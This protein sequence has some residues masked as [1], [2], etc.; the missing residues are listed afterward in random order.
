MM[1]RWRE[2]RWTALR[3]AL[4]AVV[5][6]F[7]NDAAHAGCPLRTKSKRKTAA[8]W[9]APLP[10]PAGTLTWCVTSSSFYGR[11]GIYDL[12]RLAGRVVCRGHGCPRHHGTLSVDV[13][14]AGCG[15]PTWLTPMGLVMFSG[16][17]KRER[18]VICTLQA[19][20]DNPPAEQDLLLGGTFAAT[21]TCDQHGLHS[22]ITTTLSRVE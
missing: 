18:R 20:A 8:V 6:L 2:T 15:D 3:L 17:W 13:T 7:L 5:A 22:A 9:T 16:S 21:F 11:T 14:A 12:A 19:V 4:A 10:P 1:A